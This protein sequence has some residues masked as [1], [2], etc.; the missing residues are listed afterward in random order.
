[1]RCA[2]GFLWMRPNAR[3]GR[4]WRFTSIE[5]CAGRP[6]RLCL[7]SMSSF[8]PAVSPS[9]LE[10]RAA[11]GNPQPGRLAAPQAWELACSQGRAQD[12]ALCRQYR[13]PGPLMKHLPPLRPQPGMSAFAGLS[14]RGASIGDDRLGRGLVRLPCIQGRPQQTCPDGRVGSRVIAGARRT[15]FLSLPEKMPILDG[16]QLPSSYPL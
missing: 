13:R 3:P 12:A 2:S 9:S 5:P 8:I 4:R 11:S 6:R 1:M 16:L 15:D 10:R 7:D 14:A